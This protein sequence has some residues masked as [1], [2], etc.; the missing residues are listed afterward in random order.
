MY[1]ASII[2]PIYNSKRT[3][4]K[5]VES[6]LF[7]SYKDIEI[8][9]VDDCSSDGSWEIC[10]N[11][12]SKYKNI[13]SIQNEI[14]S[15]V[16]YTRNRGLDAASGNYILFCDS[17]DWISDE[18]VTTL[19]K[20]A[21]TTPDMLICCGYS[22][23]FVEKQ[24]MVV[25][26]SSD[27][28]IIPPADI[29]L[30]MDKELIHYVWNKCF[31]LDIIRKANIRFD[32]TQ[33]M[34][35]DFQF[36]L[37]YMKAINNWS[38]LVINKPLYFYSQLNPQSLVSRWSRTENLYQAVRRIEQLAVISGNAELGNKKISEL[39]DSFV[40]FIA[41]DSSRTRHQ[42]IQDIEHVRNDGRA[43]RHYLMQRWF[44]F[45]EKLIKLLKK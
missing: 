14:N 21:Q 34:G 4:H 12:S 32:E 19:I 41:R 18:Y 17:D 3:L 7:N 10:R 33:Y 38:C 16:S 2:I 42:R 13:I 27:N 24:Q 25:I 26:S 6:I 23:C 15:G 9:L 31:L 29:F 1:T 37:D 20:Q 30:L 35:E 5:C 40:Y 36:V 43:T 22:K 39:K 44:Y 28:N 8:I 11:F 45:K